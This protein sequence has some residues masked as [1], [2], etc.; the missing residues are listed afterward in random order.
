M[1]QANKDYNYPSYYCH[2][3]FPSREYSFYVEKLCYGFFMIMKTTTGGVFGARYRRPANME[4]SYPFSLRW[5]LIS[6]CPGLEATRGRFCTCTIYMKLEKVKLMVST[7]NTSRKHSF[8]C[9]CHGYFVRTL[10]SSST[11]K[12]K[13]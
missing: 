9:R 1:H 6:T 12:C 5:Q 4:H 3:C 7:T 13:K 10:T 11:T 8:K 2:L